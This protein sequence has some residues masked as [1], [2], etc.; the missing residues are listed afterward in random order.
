MR[1]R[2]P[3]SEWD[4]VRKSLPM[5]RKVF[6][7]NP[8]SWEVQGP[9]CHVPAVPS[10]AFAPATPWPGLSIREHKIQPMLVV[11]EVTTEI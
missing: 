6:P 7:A 8:E 2:L 3:K 1:N 11:A 4:R 10:M 9:L 5:R